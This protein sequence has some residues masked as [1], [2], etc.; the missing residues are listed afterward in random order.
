MFAS[1]ARP[2]GA[3]SWRQTSLAM[4]RAN[5]ATQLSAGE[6]LA[7]LRQAAAT[8][9]Q[10]KEKSKH[11]ESISREKLSASEALTRELHGALN[12]RSKEH[13][14]LLARVSERTAPAYMYIRLRSL[15]RC[16]VAAS[17]D[18]AR[19]AKT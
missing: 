5:D 9:H 16:F 3:V 1:A 14:T 19:I 12:H 2:G 11:S 10:E 4:P 7:N 18:F 6:A 17:R 15:P 8:M 13:A